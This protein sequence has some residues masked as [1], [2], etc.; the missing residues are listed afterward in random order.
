ML[1]LLWWVLSATI[2]TQKKAGQYTQ[3]EKPLKQ[4]SLN[5]QAGTL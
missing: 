3:L 4:L 1:K 5:K 2:F